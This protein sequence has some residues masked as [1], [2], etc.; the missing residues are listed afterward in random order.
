[1]NRLNCAALCAAL[2]LGSSDSARAAFS[3]DTIVK[4]GD[5][6]PDSPFPF[7]PRIRP[8]VAI[9]DA[10]D[11]LVVAR[12]LASRD[13]LYLF[14]AGGAPEA[15]AT[16]DGPA[17]GGLP[18]KSSKAFAELSINNAG[19]IAFRGRTSDRK[20]TLFFRPAGGSLRKLVSRGENSPGGGRFREFTEITRITEVGQIAFI[21][22]VGNGPSGAFVYDTTDDSLIPVALDGDTLCFVEVR[23][24][25]TD[26][27]G[28]P[29]E[30]IDRRKRR[31]LV[32]AAA[33]LLARGG[34]PRYRNVRFD[35]VAVRPGSRGPRI[36]L[37][38]DAFRSD[39][40]S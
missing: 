5:P 38:R 13:T 36:G 4:S 32:W 27:Y 1:M 9:N 28:S 2:L 29:E 37:L 6:S 21:A 16:G 17:P 12:P 20:R 8:D 35:V 11:A 22:E 15:I 33:A 39:D 19:D 40:F 7:G 18:F 30:S 10:G 24:R 31:R 26:R 34:L 23:L 25:S 3:C 14:P